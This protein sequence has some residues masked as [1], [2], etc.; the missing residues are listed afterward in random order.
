[1][2]TSHLRRSAILLVF[3]AI[4]AAEPQVILLWPTGAP[5]SEGK[6]GEETMRVSPQGDH[7]IA[8]V[9]HPS[10]TAYL[11]AKEVATGAAVVIAPGG[12]HSE[13]WV[14]S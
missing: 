12:G 6:T 5:G 8:G 2:D 13:L 4:A 7:I 11:P 3:A 14:R 9:H 10:I 1:M